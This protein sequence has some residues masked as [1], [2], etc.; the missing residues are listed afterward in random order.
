[1]SLDLDIPFVPSSDTRLETM[2]EFAAVK[3]GEKTL[4]VGSGDGKV[5]IALAKQGAMAHGIEIDPK[6]YH[7]SL[8]N[9]ETEGVSDQA[10][11]YHLNFWDADF[12]PYDLITVYGITGIMTRLGDKIKAQC[13][14]ECRIV[15]NAFTIPHWQPIKKANGVYLYL[16][17]P[18]YQ[19]E[20]NAYSQPL[21][22]ALSS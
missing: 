21:S 2:M 12:S 15:S 18:E 22:L 13:K 6:R 4:D 7:L 3:P 20:S 17:L 1:M 14:P 10:H 8:Q 16:N 11:I 5:V 19:Q 9:I